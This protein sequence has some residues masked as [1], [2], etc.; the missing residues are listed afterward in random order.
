MNAF[1]LINAASGSCSEADET[2]LA[3]QIE[4]SGNTV[5]GTWCGG[6]DGLTEAFSA[7]ETA[8]PDTLI[9]LGGDGTIRSAIETCRPYVNNFI[10]LPG[11]TMNLLARAIYGEGNWREILHKLLSSPKEVSISSGKVG[12]HEFYV[13]AVLGTP[14]LLAHTREAIRAGDVG[15]AVA[16]G[17][18]VLATPFM[19]FTY[20][21]ATEG[22]VAETLLITTPLVSDTLPNEAK[23]LDVAAISIPG[24]FETL[25]MLSA[26][27]LGIWRNDEN[28]TTHAARMVRVVAPEPI[29]ATLDGEPV[30]LPQDTQIEFIPHSFRVLAPN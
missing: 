2:E 18:S 29:P 6:G 11:G 21:S 17:A 8:S 10:L 27:T 15:T 25:R 24:A 16:H 7:V 3:D 5:V 12:S 9:I 26:A 14:S 30:E 19:S 1:I 4:A 13:A 20:E 22:G 28:V 23:A